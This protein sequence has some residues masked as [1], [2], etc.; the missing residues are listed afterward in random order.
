MGASIGIIA[1]FFLSMFTNLTGPQMYLFGIITYLPTIIQFKIQHKAFKVLSRTMLGASI[2]LMWISLLFK[3]D[4]GA[5][6]IAWKIFCVT[7]FFLVFRLTL[8]RRTGFQ[9]DP[10]S[11]CDKGNYPFCT[12]KLP[13]IKRMYRTLSS[14][15]CTTKNLDF[16]K[17]IE[18]VIKQMEGEPSSK[19]TPIEFERQ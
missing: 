1:V 8:T 15:D 13:D 17:F 11:T 3:Y 16:T 6:E 14:S 12:H 5:Y 10:C 19:D 4:W 7:V 9:D 18:A 2:A